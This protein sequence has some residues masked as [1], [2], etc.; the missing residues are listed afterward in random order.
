MKRTV[1]V[2]GSASVS[3]EPDCAR[4]NCGVQV[5]GT[6]AQDALR[7]SNEAM[8][9][10]IDA[11]KR[12][13][14]EPADIRTNGPNLFPAEKG[15]YGGN[16]VTVVIRSL[17]TLG[18][19][20]DAVALAGG[21]NLTMHGVQF[22]VSDPGRHLPAARRAAMEAA[23]AIAGE[24]AVAG[25]AAVGKVLTI[26]ESSGA[27]VPVPMAAAGIRLMKDSPVEPGSQEIRVDVNVTY[28][29]VDRD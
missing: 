14:V 16:D 13:G 28:Q 29:L 3:V 1:S 27:Q 6:N 17:P 9:A 5:N 19:A 25:G 22:S 26:D 21:P 24:L 18:E 7:R 8:H 10:I 12:N 20:I 15:Y 4:L 2:V 11:L 23:Y